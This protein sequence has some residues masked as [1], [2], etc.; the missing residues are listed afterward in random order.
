M[1]LSQ[2]PES[3]DNCYVWQTATIASAFGDHVVP[4]FVFEILGVPSVPVDGGDK[5]NT[6]MPTLF[7]AGFELTVAH[8]LP[9]I[10]G[11]A[12]HVHSPGC[13]ST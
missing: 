7:E 6:F 11:S 12:P 4:I 9:T 1:D 2:L 13:A 5:V 8:D 3:L 10:I